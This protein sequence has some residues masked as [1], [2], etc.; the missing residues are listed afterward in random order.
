M[1]SPLTRRTFLRRASAFSLA[2]SAALTAEQQST[3]HGA[4]APTIAPPS[5]PLLHALEIPPFVDPLPIPPVVDLTHP[6]RR[7]TRLAPTHRISMREIH[8][9]LHR[10]LPPARL[11]SYGT[12][13]IGPT[14]IAR[15]NTPI[16]IQWSNDLPRKHFLPI[17][18]TLHGCGRDIPEVR[19]S[20]HVHGARVPTR[21]DGYPEDWF[22]PGTSKTS[23]YPLQQEAATLWYHDHAMGI[24]RLNHYAGLFGAFLIRDAHEDALHL[25]SGPYEIP[26]FFYDRNLTRDGQ[27]FYPTSPDPEKPWVSEFEGDALLIN[28]K[29]RPFLDVEP[30]LYRFRTINAANSRFYGLTLSNKQP[31]IQIG[32]DQGLLAAPVELPRLTI[33]P[34]ERADLL[35]DFTQSA[36][37]TLHLRTGALDILEFRVA[38]KPSLP[39]S[40]IPLPSLF[41]P[42]PRTP[43]SA[44]TLT[45]RITLNEYQDGAQNSMLMLLNRRHWHEPVTERPKLNSTEIWEFVNQTEDVHP[46]HLHLVRFQILD[47]RPFDTFA[48]LMKKEMRFT[49]PPDPPAP[50][51]LGW[52]DIA[53][54][55]PGI[56]T[57]ILVK[58]EGYPGD[59]L[60]HCHIL[61][62]EAND[63]MRPFE[64]LA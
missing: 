15:A 7:A 49:G 3:E 43:E 14:L 27:L 59:Y 33:A 58:F 41:R 13:A 30:R 62:H 23:L 11:W 38:P 55:P 20:V 32:S 34:G 63:M 37:Q 21:D 2:T 17:D 1:P 50:N 53:Q 26:L 64:V 24:N 45:R 22:V 25:P 52:K 54:C 36:G 61:E 5:V 12:G 39:S 35:I 48:F 44:A 47:R 60:Y 28:G 42:L 46:M 18:Y 57:R 4:K 31:L 6:A 16:S 56:I 51:E 40:R 19:S 9:S 29:I 8:V 10:D